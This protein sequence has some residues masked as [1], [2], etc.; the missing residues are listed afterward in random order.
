MCSNWLTAAH[1]AVKNRMSSTV[2]WWE[3]AMKI[4]YPG[5]EK[6][7]RLVLKRFNYLKY[8]F[9]KFIL[10]AVYFLLVDYHILNF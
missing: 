2:N 4:S 1:C 6:Y 10:K 3:S 8:L 5:N 7:V 9:L